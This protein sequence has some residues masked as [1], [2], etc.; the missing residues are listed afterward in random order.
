MCHILRIRKLFAAI[1]A[2][3]DGVFSERMQEGSD[4]KY[5]ILI[6][7]PYMPIFQPQEAKKPEACLRKY[8]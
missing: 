7:N 3:I 4:G 1:I 5:K 2:V 6:R 8:A